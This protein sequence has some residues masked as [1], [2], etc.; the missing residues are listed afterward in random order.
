LPGREHLDDKVV[1]MFG[2]SQMIE[3]IRK[4]E[5]EIHWEGNAKKRKHFELIELLLQNYP[6]ETIRFI[7][8]VKEKYNLMQ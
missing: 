1:K 5:S 4:G 2:D 7:A 6:T 8:R 3:Y